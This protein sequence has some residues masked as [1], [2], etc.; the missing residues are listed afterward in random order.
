[1]TRTSSPPRAG[2]HPDY[3]EW[4]DLGDGLPPDRIRA[5]RA[6][7]VQAADAERKRLARNLHD[8]AQQRLASLSLLLRLARANV[9]VD[10][11]HAE[12]LL[13]DAAVELDAAL[14]EL[15]ELARGLHPAILGDH[16]LRRALE[17]LVERAPFPVRVDAPAHRLP[18]Q[19]ETAAYYIASEGLANASKHAEPQSAAVVVAREEDSVSVEVRDDGKGG[20]D[21]AGSGL[22]GL[23]DRAEALGGHLT[24]ESPPG[25]GTTL[26]A[27]LPLADPCLWSPR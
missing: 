1:M 9:A 11:D 13:G 18:E 5:S 10:P 2:A 15:R 20:A 22:V 7:I 19:V 16:G 17:L 23:R 8:G 6:R 26:R 27:V 24:V 12:R 14:R 21:P 4:A 25:E 3:A